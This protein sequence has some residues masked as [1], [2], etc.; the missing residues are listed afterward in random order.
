MGRILKHLKSEPGLVRVC[1]YSHCS[2]YVRLSIAF[3]SIS[4]MLMSSRYHRTQR[5]VEADE[6][7]C[8]P[9]DGTRIPGVSRLN[10]YNSI[11]FLRE[12]ISVDGKKENK[13]LHFFSLFSGTVVH[14]SVPPWGRDREQQQT[15]PPVTGVSILSSEPV[16]PVLSQNLK[17]HSSDCAFKSNH[18]H[19]HSHTYMQRKRKCTTRFN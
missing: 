8:P 11:Q 12:N 2:G 16:D 10:P 4:N 6:M 1:S 5:D 19:A 7:L 18:P 15:T 14:S 13:F 17:F 3:R 9:D